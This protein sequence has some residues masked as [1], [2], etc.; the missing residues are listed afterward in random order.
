MI[1]EKGRISYI[2]FFIFAAAFILVAAKGLK[3]PQPGDENTYYYMGKL[4]AEGKFPYKDFFFAHPPLHA[5][6]LALVYKLFG[7]NIVALKSIPLISTLISSFFVFKIS[8][9]QFGQAEAIISSL[10]FLFSYGIMF[11][12]VFSFG[13]D[14]AIMLFVVGIYLLWGKNK[15]IQAG[16]FFGLAG[17]TK[18]LA[19]VPVLVVLVIILFSDRKKFL[20]LSSGFLAVF[21]LVN[22]I[23]TLLYGSGYLNPV[24]KFH[25]LKS[26]GGRENYQE[27]IGAIKLNWILFSSALLSVF[28]KKGEKIQSFAIISIAYIIFL[29]TLKNIFGFYFIAVFPLLAVIGGYSIANILKSCFTEKWK[30]FA[31]TILVLIF[32][33]D[34]ASN[35]MFLEKIA[36][37]GF[38]RGKDIVDLINS[39]SGKETL[40]FGD[41]SVVPL[42]ALLTGKEI[43]LD[44]VDTNNQVF[45]SGL[46]DLDRALAD[47]KGKDVLFVIRTA[48]GISN[49]SS[50]KRFLNENC[51]FLSRFHDKIEGSYIIYRCRQ[52]DNFED[53]S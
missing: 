45:I 6:L 29:A 15:H 17:A 34:L 46:G 7:F 27:Y 25:L 38:E 51:G 52:I 18:L 14:A 33:W 23:F 19:L 49:F 43:A 16:I 50:V 10:L 9:E 39:A 12:S 36:F 28:V 31:L 3:T 20:R 22:G 42:L 11:N 53:F 35:I 37:T 30:V 24:Y 41:N 4:I 21:F 48:Q 32:A 8:K 13:M 26:F 47:L 2:F 5:Y 1:K 44:F 40:L